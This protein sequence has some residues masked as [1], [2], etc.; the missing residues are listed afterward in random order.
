MLARPQQIKPRTKMP[1]KKTMT[2]TGLEHARQSSISNGPG[3]CAAPGAALGPDSDLIDPG[4][5]EVIATWPT[6]PE[7][8]RA[9]VLAKVRQATVNTPQP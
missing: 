3:I 8:V 9:V 7:A 4:L 6:L 1:A 5:A 2:P